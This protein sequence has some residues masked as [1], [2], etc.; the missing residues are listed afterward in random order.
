M[1]PAMISDAQTHTDAPAVNPL[2]GESSKLR[3]EA[4]NLLG[5]RQDYSMKAND[6]LPSIGR[7]S[8]LGGGDAMSTKPQDVSSEQQ[9]TRRMIADVAIAGALTKKDTNWSMAQETAMQNLESGKLMTGIRLQDRRT[10]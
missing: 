1:P 6:A 9:H 4:V 8:G 10:A 3:E 2:F 5:E 7:D